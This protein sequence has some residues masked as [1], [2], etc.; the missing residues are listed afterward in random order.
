MKW[1]EGWQIG[2]YADGTMNEGWNMTQEYCSIVSYQS[3][4]YHLNGVL[5][6]KDTHTMLLVPSEIQSTPS[7][8]SSLE[9][10]PSTGDTYLQVFYHGPILAVILLIWSLKSDYAI[11]SWVAVHPMVL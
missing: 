7:T 11:N 10:C 5:T 3:P 8:S 2:R 1:E 9:Q 6:Y 4:I